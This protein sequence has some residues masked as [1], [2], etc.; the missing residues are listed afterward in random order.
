M[1]AH[2][3]KIEYF[4]VN[5]LVL[6]DFLLKMRNLQTI[7]FDRKPVMCVFLCVFFQYHM[8]SSDIIINFAI[9]FHAFR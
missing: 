9:L 6:A 7:L 2:V 5:I 3:N 8:H 4:I 1:T